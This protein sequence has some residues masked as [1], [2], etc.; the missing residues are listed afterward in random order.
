MRHRLQSPRLIHIRR[1]RPAFTILEATVVLTVVAILLAIVAPRFADLRDASA[2]RGAMTEVGAAFALARQTAIARRAPASVVVDTAA[3]IVE[4][5]AVGARTSYRR[6]RDLYG[7]VLGSNRDSAVYDARGL[8]YGVTNLTVTIRRG[9][10]V[11]TLTMS[12]LGRTKW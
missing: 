8:G 1:N 7:I 12:R 5:R 6:L 11:D 4:V 3:G 10:F 9:R 2:V